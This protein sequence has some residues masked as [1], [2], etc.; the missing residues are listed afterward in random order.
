M[1]PADSGGRILT[2]CCSMDAVLVAAVNTK[3]GRHQLLAFALGMELHEQRG[4]TMLP[5]CLLPREVHTKWS[6]IL[7]C[8]FVLFTR[9][10]WMQVCNTKS[11]PLRPNIQL[12][13]DPTALRSELMDKLKQRYQDP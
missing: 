4:K 8:S 1:Y 9:Y 5:A 11:D 13:N 2:T 6:D 12:P 7:A 3:E 10:V